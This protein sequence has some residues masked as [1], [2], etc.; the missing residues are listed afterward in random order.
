[1]KILV[2][3]GAG[4]IGSFMTTLLLEKGYKVVVVDNL[5]RGY[6]YAVDNRAE[7]IIGDLNKEDFVSGIFSNNEFEGIIHFAGYISMAE[8]ME[9][10][11]IYFQN[12][13]LAALN[14]I[15]EA[16][17]SKNPVPIIFSSTAGVYGNPIRIPIPENHPRNPTNP[18]GE[19]KLMVEKALSWYREIYGLSFVGLRYF[20]AAGASSDGKMGENHNPETHIIPN[21][22]KSAINNSEFILYGDD[23]KTEDGT[24]IRDYIHVL[25]L[26]EAHVLALE[27]LQENKGGFFYN[28]G[29]GKGY[30]NR[31]IVDM[32]KKVSGIDF[33][34]KIAQRRPGDAERLV[35]DPTTINTE[36]GFKPKYSDIE[37]IVRTAFEWHKQN[38]K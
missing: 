26:V 16:A 24:C 34:V 14:V 36:L 5:S 33:K 30:S 10:P 12:N 25:D 13:F 15:D 21:A 8:S 4:Y 20:N 27:K 19:S 18:Y 37:T 28:A 11:Y 23:Y 32:V 31:D 3:G 9:N 2:T 17:K 7:F 35:A 22:I 1:M 29:T 38:S 6:K